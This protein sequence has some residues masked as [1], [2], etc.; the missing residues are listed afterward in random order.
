MRTAPRPSKISHCREANR[1]SRSGRPLPTLLTPTTVPSLLPERHPAQPI[2]EAHPL[3]RPARD[4]A[5][6][7][8]H[9]QARVPGEEVPGPQQQRHRL[10]RHDGEVLRR[11]EVHDAEGV[12]QD[13]VRVVDGLGRVGLDPGGQALRG[14]AG[15]LRDVAAGRVDLV[16]GVCG[17][18][19][20]WV[21]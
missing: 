19:R 6:A 18:V 5:V 2:D 1:Y 14:V 11:G 21:A 20:Q 3:P 17:S 10:G 15:G 13:D 4:A 12:P 7:R 9:V 8:R 16:V